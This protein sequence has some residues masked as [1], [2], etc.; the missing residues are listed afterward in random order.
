[1]ESTVFKIATFNANSIRMRMPIILKWLD[2]HRPDVLAIQETK[3]QDADFPQEAFTQQGWKV[4]FRGQKSYNGVSLISRSDPQKIETLLFPDSV[5]EEARFIAATFGK[6]RVVNTYIPQGFQIESEK[7]QFKLNY[8]RRL[9]EYFHQTISR[10]QCALWLG[11]LNVAPTEIDLYDPLHNQNHVCFHSEVRQVFEK[12]K[13]STWID[14]FREKEKG[15]G[16]Y[17]FWDYRQP[18]NFELNRGW[19]IDHILGTESMRQLLK[20]IW[21]DKEPRS[22]AKASDH[23]FLVA[24][25]LI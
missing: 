22:A 2:Q 14:L 1:M 6:I 9:Q 7:Y 21:I 12:T 16:H 25:F 15:P 20:S 8:F 17:T 18:M 5:Q 10:T 19:R 3:V 11:D 23:T 4:I 13:G 24:E